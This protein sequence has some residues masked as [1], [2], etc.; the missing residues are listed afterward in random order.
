MY[1]TRKKDLNL[2]SVYY[3]RYDLRRAPIQKSQEYLPFCAKVSLKPEKG[4][5][6]LSFLTPSINCQN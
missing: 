6:E 3:F 2:D 1:F 4:K 5:L